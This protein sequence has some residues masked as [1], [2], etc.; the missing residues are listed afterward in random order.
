MSVK[1]Q[2]IQSLDILS[3][4]DLRQV[5]EF[6]AFLKFRP[7]LPS[8]GILDEAQV[9]TLYA[10]DVDEDQE[11]AEA[12]LGEYVYTLCQEDAP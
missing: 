6:V 8:A 9:A 11:L 4:D 10:A 1:E 3:E 2:V 5:A 12:G 7:R